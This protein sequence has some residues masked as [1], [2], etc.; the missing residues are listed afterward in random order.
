MPTTLML[1]SF[2]A[3]EPLHRKSLGTLCFAHPFRKLVEDH[4]FLTTMRDRKANNSS[5]GPSRWH[6]RY[7]DAVFTFVLHIS[8]SVRK[9][10]QLMSR[11]EYYHLDSLTI[12]PWPVAFSPFQILKGAKCQCGVEL[13]SDAFGSTDGMPVRQ[14]AMRAYLRARNFKRRMP[15]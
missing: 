1:M 3:S 13:G 4:C 9:Q 2:Y 6:S 14:G 7:F 12:T 11:P 5:S 10:I 8:F 15:L